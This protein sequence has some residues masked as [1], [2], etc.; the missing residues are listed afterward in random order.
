[1]K[2]KIT[3]ISE[4]NKIMGKI[5]DI[6]YGKEKIEVEVNVDVY[7]FCQKDDERVKRQ[8]K[9]FD[10]CLSVESLTEKYDGKC[11]PDALKCQSHEAYCTEK[12]VI[13]C[14]RKNFNTLL[15]KEKQCLIRYY[16]Q[17]LT[18]EETAKLENISRETV[19]RYI[20]SAKEKLKKLVE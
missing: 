8:D 13:N 6:F 5:M 4:E 17:H 7:L 1:M 2:L 14:L 11:L 16:Y 3:K 18:I 19:K 15:T 10:R 12:D 9:K 20:K